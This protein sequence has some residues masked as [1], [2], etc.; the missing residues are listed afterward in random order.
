[1]TT[2]MK[3]AVIGSRAFNDYELLKSKL[4][5]HINEI[6]CILSGGAKGADSLAEKF[7]QEYKIPTKIFL[8][9]WK[10]FGRSAGIARNK[11]IVK[12]ADL[13]FIF[14]DGES[15]GTKSVVDSCRSLKK[16]SKVFMI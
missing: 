13:C 2:K 12:E 9:D 11:E 1:M 10:Q 16:Q 14:W 7:A 15:K 5:E 3:V 6:E 8:P 4:L